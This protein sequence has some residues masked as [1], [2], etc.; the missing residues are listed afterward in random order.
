MQHHD[1]QGEHLLLPARERVGPLRP[2]LPQDREQFEDPVDA[3]TEVGAIRAVDEPAHL[4]ILG[5][6]HLREDAL[7]TLQEVDAEPVPLLGSG[8]G[9]VPTVQSDDTA[10]RDL[11]TGGDPQCRRLSGPVGPEQRQHFP[12]SAPR[13]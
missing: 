8:V 10:S 11:E 3:T 13:S 1:R 4:E 12:A 2:A 9:D 5:D 6:G 7:A